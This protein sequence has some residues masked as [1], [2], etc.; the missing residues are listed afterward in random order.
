MKRHQRYRSN[1]AA[2]IERDATRDKQPESDPTTTKQ[3]QDR[4][5]AAR[6]YARYEARGQEHGRDLEDWFEAER[7]LNEKQ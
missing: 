7:E 1:G 5:V 2:S 3:D 6:A 4:D